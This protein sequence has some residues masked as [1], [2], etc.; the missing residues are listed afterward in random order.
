MD[1]SFPFLHL[2][3]EL[4]GVIR[5]ILL[6]QGADGWQAAARLARTCRQLRDEYGPDL[7]IPHQ[8]WS[9]YTQ[10]AAIWNVEANNNTRDLVRC[11]FRWLKKCHLTDWM[12]M[13][14]WTST[15]PDGSKWPTIRLCLYTYK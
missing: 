12:D 8:W 4:R 1:T 15:T 11:I 13:R 10:W 14:W 3:P 7:A 5:A 2:F 6:A 9:S